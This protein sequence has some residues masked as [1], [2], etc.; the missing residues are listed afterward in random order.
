MPG[1]EWNTKEAAW[2]KH[3]AA[4]QQFVEREGHGD[5][6]GRHLERFN[7]AELKLGS[8][9]NEQ[10]TTRKEGAL[11]PERSE[12]LGQI[13][14]WVWDANEAAWQKHYAALQQ[15]TGRE[16][17][18]DLAGTHLET[19]NGEQLKL[20]QWTNN[21]R[22]FGNTGRLRPDRFQQLAAHPSW[23]WSKN[24]ASW[25]THFAAL[26]QFEGREGHT[27]IPSQHVE[28]F[29]GG[30]LN[31]GSWVDVQRR[32]RK[33]DKLATEQEAALAAVPGWV[34][35]AREA[36]WQNNYSAL[37]QFVAREGHANVKQDHVETFNA[38]DLKL[39]AWVVR[40]R[41]GKNKNL[42]PERVALLDAV[43]GWMWDAREAAWQRHLAALQEFVTSEGHANVKQGHV[44][45][46]NGE[47]LKLGGWVDRQ[48]Q[49]H[50]NGKLDP[51]RKRLLDEVPG[52][53]W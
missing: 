45:V 35:D 12:L 34:W 53:R 23:V 39:G 52:W 37:H 21:Q 5:V 14:G 47:D 24:E 36:A 6:P 43:P 22:S 26:Q 10:R 44:E 19:F 18:A 1:W 28:S 50:K 9:V 42:T 38:E 32:K 46:F 4:L 13:A 11:P 16:G 7:G 15:F 20:G 51:E 29:N 8:W 27:D 48:R 3:Y 25:R 30:K 40:Q 33:T 2:Q 41:S 31:L 49:A 17:H